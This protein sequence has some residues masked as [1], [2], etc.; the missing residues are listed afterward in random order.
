MRDLAVDEID[1]RAPSRLQILP[2]GGASQAVDCQH[3]GGKRKR[4]EERIG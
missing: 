4:P 3:S 1:F 2:H